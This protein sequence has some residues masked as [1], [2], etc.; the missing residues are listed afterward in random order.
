[1]FSPLVF[2]LFDDTAA[3]SF[4]GSK[5]CQIIFPL[6]SYILFQELPGV[7]AT[8]RRLV[9]LIRP[10][11]DWGAY[12]Y[13]IS[14]FLGFTTWKM[15]C[16]FGFL[17]VNTSAVPW[18]IA[19]TIAGL[20]PY[21][22]LQYIVTYLFGQKMLMQGKLNPFKDLPPPPITERPPL[23]KQFISKFFH[24]DMN[25][26]SANV[27]LRRVFVKPLVD[28]GG[29]LITW[30]L[31]NVGLLFSQSGEINFSPMI[32]FTFLAIF[33]FYVVNVLGYILGYNIGEFLYFVLMYLMEWLKKK[34]RQWQL[35]TISEQTF[36][37]ERRNSVLLMLS[38][39]NDVVLPPYKQ[40]LSRYGLN[41]RWLMSISFGVLSVIFLEPF[42]SA[43]IF[44]T[45]GAIQ[46]AWFYAFGQID[47]THVHQFL[48]ASSDASLLDPSLLTDQFQEPLQT[49]IAA[50]QT[51]SS[52]LIEVAFMP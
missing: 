26:T 4:G 47:A 20:I 36:L 6:G 46:Q 29:I 18:T 23:W 22:I 7:K 32:N 10:N 51:P 40:F 41:L 11:A 12:E 34:V 14:L 19:F 37:T 16:D 24:E 30:P 28:Y 33:T 52:Q 3:L 44:S 42:M 5:L 31:Y 27:P 9:L 50:S 38:M 43:K 49:L 2:A 1:M 21:A 45:A 48:A 15:G 17:I 35:Y 25:V 39:V 8:L 13:L